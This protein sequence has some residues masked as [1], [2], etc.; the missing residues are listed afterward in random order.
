MYQSKIY[1]CLRCETCKSYLLLFVHLGFPKY[2]VIQ[3]VRD[4]NF[5]P[6]NCQAEKP[7]NSWKR[8]LRYEIYVYIISK[9]IWILITIFTSESSYKI[10]VDNFF[11]KY[12]YTIL[13]SSKLRRQRKYNWDYDTGLPSSRAAFMLNY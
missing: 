5:E 1:I 8:C 9:D 2:L 3:L 10:A 13:S 7:T 6:Q 4:E 12:I 11:T